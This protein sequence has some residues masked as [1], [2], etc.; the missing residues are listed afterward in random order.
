LQAP[1]R[2]HAATVQQRLRCFQTC[3]NGCAAFKQRLRC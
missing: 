1:G 2:L 3:S